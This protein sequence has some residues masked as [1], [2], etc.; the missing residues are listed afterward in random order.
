MYISSSPRLIL[1][2]TLLTVSLS[3]NADV[4]DI[5]SGRAYKE[6]IAT[7]DKN[8]QPVIIKFYQDSCPA[9]VA[10]EKP[11]RKVAQE[12]T[13]RVLFLAVDVEKAKERD[14]LRVIKNYNIVGVPLF[15]YHTKDGETKKAG[16]ITE[17]GFRRK[18]GEVLNQSG[19]PRADIAPAL[20]PA[21]TAKRMRASKRMI[22]ADEA[23]AMAAGIMHIAK[24]AEYEKALKDAD[25]NNMPVVVKFYAEWCPPCKASAK[26]FKKV[27]AEL[28]DQVVFIEIDTD[29]ADAK[30]KGI[31]SKLSMPGIP[32]FI[33]HS[34]AGETKRSGGIQEASFKK[35]V[36]DLIKKAKK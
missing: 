22:A 29:K 36:Q 26:P 17:K 5:K 23:P 28:G 16:S 3:L 15:V 7:A 8:N 21:P 19:S 34:T 30:L 20:A 31:M 10:S 4:L 6:A 24:G 1:A 9:C 33:Y 25:N 14:L 11:F 2:T 13:D 32:F 12:Y 18:V 27:A 35:D